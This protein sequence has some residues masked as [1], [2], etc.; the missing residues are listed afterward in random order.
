MHHWSGFHFKRAQGY[1]ILTAGEE[2]VQ[3]RWRKPELVCGLLRESLQ[4]IAVIRLI[5]TEVLGTG[6]TMYTEC[7]IKEIKGIIFPP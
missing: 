4:K 7:M 2:H 3:Q 5:R 1:N 6:P